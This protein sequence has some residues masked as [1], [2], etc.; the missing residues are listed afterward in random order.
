M[1]DP[2]DDAH[3]LSAALGLRAADRPRVE[4]R[5]AT[6]GGLRGLFWAGPEPFDDCLNAARARRLASIVAVAERM[7]APP[8]LPSR[9]DGAADVAAYFRPLLAGQA[10]E[11]FWM[12][13]LDARGR[14]IAAHQIALGTLTCCLVHP[15]EVFAPA[16]RARAAQI[17]LVHNHPSGD[18]E[19]SAEDVALTE[20]ITEAGMLLGIPVVDHVVVASGGYRSIGIPQTSSDP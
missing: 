20:R 3:L 12:L 16:I 4:A 5:L 15:R 17:V 6:V 9:V 2:R 19:P 7:L 10:A 11:S 1:S 8:Q 14:P 13:M 18:P